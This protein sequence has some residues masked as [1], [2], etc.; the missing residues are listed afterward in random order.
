VPLI[1]AG[2]PGT[3]AGQISPAFTHVTDIAPTLLALA[4]VAQPDGSYQG[5]PVERMIG[6]NLLPLM[7]GQ[8][9]K[10]YPADQPV[11]YELSGN[12]AIFKGDF[13]LLR[14]L[15]PIGDG[16]WHLYDLSRDPGETTDLQA[17]HPELFQQMISDYEAYARDNG[18]LPMPEGYD[19]FN[20]VFINSI[21]NVYLPQ[22]KRWGI[23]LLLLVIAG[24]YLLRRRRKQR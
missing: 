20:Q 6:R 5:K 13:K 2:A 1:I 8:A 21:I 4:G 22:V 23:P 14:N 7:R 24:I 19:P 3:Q 9:E 12:A 15:P 11:G 18:V 10:V 17:Q 16:Q